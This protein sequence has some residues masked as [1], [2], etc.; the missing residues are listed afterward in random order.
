MFEKHFSMDSK[1]IEMYQ[2]AS[3]QALNE[4]YQSGNMSSWNPN[5]PDLDP[6]WTLLAITDSEDGAL[7]WWARPKITQN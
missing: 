4:Y 1:F 2:Q 5:P 6:D 3:P 7:A